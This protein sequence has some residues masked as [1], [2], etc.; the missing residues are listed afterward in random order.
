MNEERMKERVIL[1][2][3]AYYKIELQLII[4]CNY[5]D[6]KLNCN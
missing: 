2:L 5:N 6:M 1:V 3:S 4:N